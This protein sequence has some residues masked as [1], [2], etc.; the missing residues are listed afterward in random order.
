VRNWLK[1]EFDISVGN[2]HCGW[3]ISHVCGLTFGKFAKARR[4]WKDQREAKDEYCLKLAYLLAREA[5]GEI[6]LVYVDESYINEGADATHGYR[7]SSFN[8][9]LV[10]LHALTKDGLVTGTPV[11]EESQRK[12]GVHVRCGI[13][14]WICP[15]ASGRSRK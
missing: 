11:G 12:D 13:S 3:L 9:V 8:P 5:A 7:S 14:R 6:V 1:S 15:G 4:Q 10:L 2:E